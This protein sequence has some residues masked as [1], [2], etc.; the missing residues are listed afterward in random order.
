MAQDYLRSPNKALVAKEQAVEGVF[1]TLD[2]AT[3]A[4]PLEDFD[5]PLNP[6]TLPSTEATGTIFESET[7]IINTKPSITGT[8]KLRGSGSVSTPPRFA[9]LLIASGHEEEVCAVIPASGTSTIKTGTGTTTGFTIDLVA[10]ADWP[11]VD[12]EMV[13]RVVTLSVNPAT[14]INVVIVGYEVTGNDAVVTL[15]HTFGVTLGNT[16][17]VVAIAG[18]MYRPAQAEPPAI[19]IAAYMDGRVRK[20]RDVRGTCGITIPG[21]NRGTLNFD[22][23][24]NLEDDDD[25]V[26]PT[27]INFGALPAP[28][29]W[30]DGRATLDKKLT[31][32]SNFTLNQNNDQTQYPNP[33][34]DTGYDENI[35]T[36]IKPGG[37]LTVN[38]ALK[39]THDRVAKLTTNTKMSWTAVL[40]EDAG[41]GARWAVTVPN[42]KLTDVGKGDRQ[43][44]AEHR[45][46]YQAVYVAPIVPYAL[47]MH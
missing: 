36:K 34:A 29:I 20:L 15:D 7:D 5:W 26:V 43:G 14:P 24:G 32:C 45:L 46:P 1:E 27:T 37:E 44:I 25:E 23:R 38:M 3:D 22:L 35:I 33:N 41:V 10:E 30:R 9:P 16:T 2:P 12:G 13:G 18:I 31:G 17:E 6:E 47:F 39:A 28:A 42:L 40:E 8:C 4:I 19:S 21:A 11:S